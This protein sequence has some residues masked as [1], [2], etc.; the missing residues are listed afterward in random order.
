[1]EGP[2]LTFKILQE[3]ATGSQH[4]RL[5][6]QAGVRR[7]YIYIYIY[8]S[9]VA[10]VPRTATVPDDISGIFVRYFDHFGDNCR[11]ILEAEGQS[12]EDQEQSQ[13]DQE[14]SQEDQDF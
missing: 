7:I 2:C 6:P 5:P 14:Q 1:M 4:A 3:L 9:T 13:E 11:L 10:C 8:I 12:Q